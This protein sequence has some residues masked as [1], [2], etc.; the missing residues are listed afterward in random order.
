[1]YFNKQSNEKKPVLQWHFIES[2]K[3]VAYVLE[4]Q[5]YSSSFPETDRY[6]TRD[7]DNILLGTLYTMSYAP[8]KIEI[9]QK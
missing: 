6:I 8:G 3:S 4:P 9:Q 7:L 2:E 1:M 5:S